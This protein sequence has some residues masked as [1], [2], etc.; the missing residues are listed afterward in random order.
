[1]GKARIPGS[2]APGARIAVEGIVQIAGI[3]VVVCPKFLLRSR[4][5]LTSVADD[6]T[7]SLQRVTLPSS[8]QS[9]K[10][11]RVSSK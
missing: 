6:L 2:Q 9:L 3:I 4:E 10:F 5:H 11:G 8:L 1:M 7:L